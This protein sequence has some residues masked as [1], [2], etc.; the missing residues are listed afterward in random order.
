M[1][2]KQRILLNGVV[3]IIPTPFTAGEEIDRAELRT[4]IDFAHAAGCCAACLPAYASE[5]YKL[6]DTERVDVV[7]EAV[8]HSSGRI[9]IIGQVNYPSSRMAAAMAATLQAEGV[10]ALGL[11]VPRLFPMPENDLRRYFDTV[12]SAVEVP[13]VIQ[14][15]NPGGSSVSVPFISALNRDY[16]HFRWIKLEAPRMASKVRA[17]LRDTQGR[18]GVIE[19]WGGM[20]MIELLPA[21]ICAIMPGLG[22][23]DLLVKIYAMVTAGEVDQAGEI[24]EGVLPQIVYSL[25]NLELYHCAEKMLLQARGLLRDA[26][27]RQAGMQLGQDDKSHINYL[28]RRLLAL[29]DRNG[30]SAN[31]LATAGETLGNKR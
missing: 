23:A 26:R 27:V 4:L 13:V 30:L 11:T 18:V 9:P 24:F 14:D 29:L 28:N 10:D 21:G 16:P 8:R 7:R 6:A 5:F 3:P 25:Q 19:G 17:I 31:P 22:L 2:G 20:Y 1:T 15:F 12:L